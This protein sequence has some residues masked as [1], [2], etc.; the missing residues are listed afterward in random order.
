M[1]TVTGGEM[2]DN[3][4]PRVT[5]AA[6]LAV[7]ALAALLFGLLA[8]HSAKT[9]YSMSIPLPETTAVAAHS[10]LAMPESAGASGT[11]GATGA[12][13]A[14]VASATVML[15]PEA[16]SASMHS[17]ML[18]CALLALTCVMFAVVVLLV[19]LLRR[20]ERHRLLLETGGADIPAPEP[21]PAPRHTHRPTLT[22]LSI[23]RT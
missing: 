18:D 17:G 22:L 13:V 19:L 14:S 16:L 4:R 8:M 12:S 20:P 10:P 9:G 15:M 2:A 11:S 6:V 5:V 1:L 21:H 7:V 23:C 3:S